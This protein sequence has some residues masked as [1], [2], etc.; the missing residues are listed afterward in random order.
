MLND[1][2][3]DYYDLFVG[4]IALGEDRLLSVLT[5][6]QSSSLTISSCL[7]DEMK[8]VVDQQI[9]TIKESRTETTRWQSYFQL[10][11]YLTTNH[12]LHFL[13]HRSHTIYEPENSP[14]ENIQLDRN[15]RIDYREV[16]KRT[17][18]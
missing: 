3:F 7:T 12:I 10:E 18:R 15:G 11:S 2:L 4:G 13:T 6:S 14:Y 5:A 9:N 16:W 1:S 8:K 17:V